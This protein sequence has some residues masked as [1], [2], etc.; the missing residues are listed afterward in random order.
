MS[1]GWH[2]AKEKDREELMAFT[3][4][5]ESWA[6]SFSDKTFGQKTWPGKHTPYIY[7]D[8]R[9]IAAV[10]FSKT[11]TILPVLTE[12]QEL[13]RQILS[14]LRDLRS[15]YDYRSYACIGQDAHVKEFINIFAL[16]SLI[17][18]EYFTM[19]FYGNLEHAPYLPGYRIERAG[20]KD[21]DD[22]LPIACLYEQEEV[23]TELHRFDP[24]HCRQG[25]LYSLKNQHV[26]LIRH[27]EKIIARAQTNAIGIGMEQVGGVYVLS[28]YRGQGLGKAIMTS[29]IVDINS[30]GKNACLFVKKKNLIAK[31]L[32]KKLGFSIEGNFRVAYLRGF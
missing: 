23:V 28:E 3:R 7:R 19:S 10:L 6:C 2:P 15:E 5:R 26:Y 18:L 32:Y 25:Q 24:R 9:I 4:K 11:G 29:L 22:L 30:R 13:N 20:M 31:N 27:G 8:G 21:L 14:E 1:P 17:A 16:Q 12:E